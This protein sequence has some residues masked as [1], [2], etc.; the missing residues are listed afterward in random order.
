MYKK[1]VIDCYY[2]NL[3]AD[4]ETQAVLQQFNSCAS[5]L[6]IGAVT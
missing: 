5:L 6:M 2:S 1:N 3:F 4:L